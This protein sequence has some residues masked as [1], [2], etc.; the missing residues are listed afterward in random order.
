M[1]RAGYFPTVTASY[2]Q[3]WAGSQISVLNNT[4]SARLSFSLPIFNGFTRETGVVRSSATQDAAVARLEDTRR[5]VD[6][7][8]TQYLLALE[9]ARLR[10]E[11][12]RASAEAAAE[13]L[14]VQQARYDLGAATIVEL[15]TSQVSLDQAE[16]DIVQSRLDYLTSKA[17]IEAL[18]G[19]EL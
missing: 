2:S 10:L 17:R 7:Q 3:N 13:D 4:W 12:A 9:S 11:I 6:A 5:Q 1:A 14:R 15:L 8:L 16:V 18:L 19:R